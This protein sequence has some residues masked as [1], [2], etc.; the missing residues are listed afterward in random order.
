MAPVRASTSL[1]IT[2]SGWAEY[3]RCC[4]GVEV[5]REHRFAPN[6]MGRIREAVQLLLPQAEHD[7]V[8]DDADWRSLDYWFEETTRRITLHPLPDD[9]LYPGLDS[10]DALW[11]WI[12]DTMTARGRLRIKT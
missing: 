4:D 9:R 11:A 10:L 7:A 6:E 8:I 5:R 12:H 2:S 1:R 3:E